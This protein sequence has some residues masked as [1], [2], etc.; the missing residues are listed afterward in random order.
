MVQWP[1]P[2]SAVLRAL[3]FGNASAGDV[4]AAKEATYVPIGAVIGKDTAAGVDGANTGV[5]LE[6]LR[7]TRDV[8]DLG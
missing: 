2:L 1:A 3:P 7:T 5:L 6:H 8:L 4:S